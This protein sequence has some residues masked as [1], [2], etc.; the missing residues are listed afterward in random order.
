MDPAVVRGRDI[1]IARVPREEARRALVC[2]IQPLGAIRARPGKRR[3]IHDQLVIV[4]RG[5]V[6][7]HH[8]ARVAQL[9]D[10]DLQAVLRLAREVPV[11]TA[12]DQHVVEIPHGAVRRIA[13]VDGHGSDRRA[14]ER[15][16]APGRRRA[17]LRALLAGLGAVIA[18]QSRSARRLAAHARIV[19]LAIGIG[20][21]LGIDRRLVVGG[22]F[23]RAGGGTQGNEER[24][25]LH[26]R[27]MPPTGRRCTAT[28]RFRRHR[29]G[30]GPVSP[31]GAR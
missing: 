9:F 3:D 16:V 23:G 27:P 25:G 24:E 12:I 14:H 13:R 10:L 15:L 17:G 11:V 28:T 5:I 29:S 2:R 30:R 7:V 21:A 31:C 20:D 6:R 4:A 22:R 19:G 18:A 26:A 8:E 1:D